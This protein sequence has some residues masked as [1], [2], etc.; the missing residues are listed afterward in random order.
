VSPVEDREVLIVGGGPAG[1]ATAIRLARRGRDVLLVERA[2]TWQWRACG[3]FTSPVTVD[4]LRRVGV[5]EVTL[6]QVARRLPAMRVETP[7]GTRFRLMY[8]DDGSLAAAA[9][10]LDRSALDP[11]L[12]DLARGAGAEVRTG[13]AA[14]EIRQ[15]QASLS[16]GG[17]VRARVIVGADGL[18]STV[19]RDAGV[20]RRP[21]LG[22]RPAL[23]FHVAEPESP[24]LAPRDARMVV[25]D[26]GY[27]GLA[28]VPGSRVNVGIVLASAV[29]RERLRSEGAAA[30]AAAVM[31]LIPMADEDPVP[32]AAPEHC[33]AIEGASPVAARVAARSGR[34]WL[35]VGD[36]AGFLD[37]FTGEGLHRALRSAELAAVAID[38][39]LAGDLSALAAYDRA[40]TRGTRA[41]DAVSLLVQA[42]LGAPP[43]FEYA[44]RR[45][46]SRSEVRETMGRVIGDLVPASTAFDPRFLVGLL[47]P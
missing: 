40:L 22:D 14:R 35:L 7:R 18:R 20:V 5:D 1:A 31:G 17:V 23:T 38:R 19:A 44:T 13:V 6:D 10:G 36:A 29:W 41:K 26:G 2:A 21:R 34:D 47:R 25:F 24:P 39:N 9:V 37:P 30:T 28:P 33:D 42:F 45:L 8:G 32:W 43:A 27:V 4:E 15:G 16:D 46:A 3:V 12:L 11:H